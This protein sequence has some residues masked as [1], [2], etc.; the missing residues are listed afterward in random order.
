MSQKT[1]QTKKNGRGKY[2]ASGI[3]F[4]SGGTTSW[5]KLV[6]GKTMAKE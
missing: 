5:R 3:N 2:C 4:A 6:D 1:V